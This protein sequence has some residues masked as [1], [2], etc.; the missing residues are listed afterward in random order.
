MAGL[1]FAATQGDPSAILRI[2]KVVIICSNV[3]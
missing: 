2:V 3:C 1:H